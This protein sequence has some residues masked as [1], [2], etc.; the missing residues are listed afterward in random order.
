MYLT[1]AVCV[2]AGSYKLFDVAFLDRVS[3][4]VNDL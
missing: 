4:E 1:D 3:D 2:D